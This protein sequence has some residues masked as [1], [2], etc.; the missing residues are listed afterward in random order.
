MEPAQDDGARAPAAAALAAQSQRMRAMS[1]PAGGWFARGI[2]A[3]QPLPSL[4]CVLLWQPAA[5]RSCDACGARERI[6]SA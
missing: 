4:N 3:L 2:L 6:G 5:N 1:G